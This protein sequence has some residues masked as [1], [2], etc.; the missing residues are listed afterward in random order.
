[1]HQRPAPTA[2][3][4]E[5][6]QAD[7]QGPQPR[8]QQQQPHPCDRHPRIG[9][10]GTQRVVRDGARPLA[11]PPQLARRRLLDLPAVGLQPVPQPGGQVVRVRSPAHTALP[12]AATASR[13]PDRGRSRSPSLAGHLEAGLLQGGD[14]VA[15]AP[16]HTV[17]DTLQQVV[18]D[19]LAR[20]GFVLEAGP[21]LR[22]LQVGA[23]AGLLRP[24]ARRVVRAAPAVLVVEGVAQRVEGL[25]PARS[26][27]MN[28][29]SAVYPA[30]RA[31][32]SSVPA[33]NAAH[34]SMS[35]RASL[36]TASTRWRYSRGRAHST[37][38]S[39][40]TRGGACRPGS[41]R[42]ETA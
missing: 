20:A 35:A 10:D 33:R 6:D 15:A 30:G 17:L 22:R 26:L 31:P 29:P 2:D 16:H 7:H 39:R 25:L 11:K 42:Q 27:S 24:G 41:S 5:K 8:V 40:L 36:I 1:M 38:R 32:S 37:F 28:D 34:C 19:Q 14:H 4:D 21:Q 13:C 3:P 18:A 23:M 9:L 12:S